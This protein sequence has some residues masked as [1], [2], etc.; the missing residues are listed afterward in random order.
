MF[1]PSL[2]AWNISHRVKVKHRYHVH[3]KYLVQRRAFP[4]GEVSVQL[5]ALI[6]TGTCLSE[7]YKAGTCARTSIIL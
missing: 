7:E 1:V 4:E 5:V 6:I 3:Q 2:D